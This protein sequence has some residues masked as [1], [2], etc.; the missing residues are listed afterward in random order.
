MRFAI[1]NETY[2]DRSFA[3]ACRHMKLAGYDG[4]EVAPFMLKEDPSTLTENEAA[5]F[6]RQANAEGL[7]VVGLHWL[8]VAPEGLHLTTPDDRVRK[9]TMAFGRHLVRICHAMA[10][11]VMVWGSPTQR[12]L[13]DDW[14]YEEAAARAA[15]VLRDIAEEAEEAGVTIALEPLARKETNFLTTAAETIE[16]IRRVD[17]PA[18]RLHLDVKAMSDEAGPIPEIIE[19]SKAYTAHFHANDPNLLGPGMGE[20][21]FAPI[22]KALE[23]TGYDGWVSVEVFDYEPGAES[24]AEESMATLR[25]VFS[26]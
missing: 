12:S 8:L 22:A 23:S 17:H 24:I 3:D 26:P 15:D 4:V 11:E 21:D 16:F 20:V 9:D 13:E 14:D 6:M 10:G 7:D 18:V 2:R 19:T 1:C 25:S 5:E